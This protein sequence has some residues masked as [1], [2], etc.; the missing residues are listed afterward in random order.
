MN[1]TNAG[2]S[3]EIMKLATLFPT[4]RLL[5]STHFNTWILT[6]TET[7]VGFTVEIDPDAT[8]DN[9]ISSRG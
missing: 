8:G 7:N 4:M 1:F 5:H 2:H 6:A 3:E 9:W